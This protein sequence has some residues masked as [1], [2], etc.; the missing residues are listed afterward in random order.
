[1]GFRVESGT[2]PLAQLLSDLIPLQLW[3]V[4]S[5]H[6]EVFP[7]LALVGPFWRL[8]RS[9]CTSGSFSVFA[10]FARIFGIVSVMVKWAARSG[11]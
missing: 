7:F 2:I 4:S 10:P 5:R 1:M 3:L 9:G 6:Q 8:A 11:R